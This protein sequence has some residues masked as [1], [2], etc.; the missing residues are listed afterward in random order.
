MPK[1]HSRDCD[2]GVAAVELAILLPIFLALTF[3]AID[4]ALAFRQQIMLRNAA[5]NAAS[6][7]AVQPC[8][9]DSGT[10]NITEQATRELQ[11]VSV[12]KPDPVTVL[13]PTYMDSNGDDVT[14]T[15]ACTTATQV[16]ITV[17]A[18][19][20][21][22]TGTVLGIFGVPQSLTISGQETVRIVGR[23]A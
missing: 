1:R 2:E 12:L 23:S 6:Y 7:A 14:G 16:Q 11:H 10:T 3:A 17:S 19:Y 13:P 5:A 8:N 20:D 22:I 9:L 18:P 15:D 4:F 21:L